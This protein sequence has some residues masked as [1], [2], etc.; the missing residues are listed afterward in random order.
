MYVLYM[1][2]VHWI[3]GGEEAL[4]TTIRSKAVKIMGK[5]MVSMYMYICSFIYLWIRNK[6]LFVCMKEQRRKQSKE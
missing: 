2:S 6:G 4:T 5:M 1:H 3:I